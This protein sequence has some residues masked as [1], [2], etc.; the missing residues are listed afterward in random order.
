MG[1]SAT[2][3]TKASVLSVSDLRPIFHSH[4]LLI[5]GI[6]FGTELNFTHFIFSELAQI[7]MVLVNPFNSQA[8]LSSWE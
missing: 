1:H 5:L 8:P 4:Y 6:V 2:V 7:L 3:R